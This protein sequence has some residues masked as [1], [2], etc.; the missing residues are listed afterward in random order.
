MYYDCREHFD[1]DTQWITVNGTHVP[2]DDNGKLSGDV[3]KKIIEESAKPKAR[4]KQSPGPSSRIAFKKSSLSSEKRE[5]YNRDFADLAT[6]MTDANSRCAAELKSIEK[7]QKGIPYNKRDFTKL[8]DEQKKRKEIS[9][10]FDKAVSEMPVGTLLSHEGVLYEKTKQGWLAKDARKDL[11]D[12]K[13]VED[14]EIARWVKCEDYLK[15]VSPVKCIESTDDLEMVRPIEM[16]SDDTYKSFADSINGVEKSEVVK[17]AKKDPEF[18]ELVDAITLYTQGAYGDQKREAKYLVEHGLNEALTT[19]AGDYFGDGYYDMKQ[20]WPGQKLAESKSSFSGGVLSMIGAINNSAETTERLYRIADDRAILSANGGK[21]YTPPKPGD[22]I[23]MDAPTSF[24]KSKEVMDEIS[25]T[26]YGDVIRYT[27]EPGAHALDIE[28]LSR[29]KQ[30]ESLCCGEF[31]VTKVSP[32][33]K[34]VLGSV[35][36]NAPPELLERVK[37]RIIGDHGDYY[38]TCAFKVE[39][40]LRQVGKTEIGKH[41]DAGIIYYDCRNHFDDDMEWITVNG[42]HIPLDDEGKPTGKIGEKIVSEAESKKNH[43]LSDEMAPARTDYDFSESD[44][45]NDFI[46]KNVP[47]LMPIFKK[48]GSEA[49]DSEFY[50]F[51]L[52]QSTKDIHEISKTEADEVVYDHVRQSLFDGWFRNA[53][54]SYK[55]A[56][57]SAMIGSQE[58]RNAG[59]SLAY[60]N[61]KN[62]AD[63]PL[64]FEEFL[65]TP[66]MMYRGGHG[67]KHTEDD[68]FSAYTFDKKT[69]EHFAGSNGVVTSAPIRPIDTYGSMRCV[70]EAEIWVP[71]E[72]APNGNQD[73]A[74]EVSGLDQ[75]L[76]ALGISK[77][78]F[79]DILKNADAKEELVAGLM[80]CLGNVPEL[81]EQASALLQFI[82]EDDFRADS[83]YDEWL[84]ENLDKFE[85][86]DDEIAFKKF[87]DQIGKSDDEDAETIDLVF[88]TW[89]QERD[90]NARNDS[91]DKDVQWITVNGTPVPL[92]ENGNITGKVAEKINAT[93]KRGSTAGRRFGKKSVR[94]AKGKL[95]KIDRSVVEEAMLSDNPIKYASENCYAAQENR[96]NQYIR[97]VMDNPAMKIAKDKY[98]RADIHSAYCKGEYIRNPE[99][100]LFTLYADEESYQT[101]MTR[102]ADTH[103]IND[104]SELTR[105]LNGLSINYPNLVGFTTTLGLETIDL[106]AMREDGGPGSGN[107]GHAGREG[108]IGG[109]APSGVTSVDDKYFPT[110]SYRRIT[111]QGWNKERRQYLS[112]KGFDATKVERLETIVTRHVQGNKVD[113]EMARF[114]KENP[115]LIMAVA[116]YEIAAAKK[117]REDE[118]A[119]A[120]KDIA[121]LNR[122]LEDTENGIKAG[123]Y[124]WYS[125]DPKEL[126]RLTEG[127]KDKIEY[128]KHRRAKLEDDS[129]TLYRA[130]GYEDNVLSFT[131]NPDGVVLY[132]G[133][134]YEQMLAP[135]HKNTLAE[136]V[137]E[138]IY[139]IGGFGAKFNFYAGE[140]SEVTFVKLRSSR[141][142]GGPGS[143]NFGHKGVPGQVGGSA[144]ADDE[145]SGKSTQRTPED[146]LPNESYQ[147]TPEFKE[148]VQAVRDAH[149]KRDEIFDRLKEMED[150]L[151]RE[152]SPKP[153][154]EWTEED[155]VDALL[156]NPPAHYTER[157]AALKKEYDE[158]KPELYKAA[159]EADAV[160]AEAG[161][162]MEI[163]RLKARSKQLAEWEQPELKKATKDQ[164]EGF[165]LETTGTSF[166]DE[167][168]GKRNTFIAEMSPKEYLERCAYEIFD[169]GTM[170]STV[171]GIIGKNAGKYAEEMKD[172]AKF[173][174]PY[175]NYNDGGQEGRHRA[176]AAYELGIDKIPVLIIGK[177]PRKSDLDF[178]KQMLGYEIRRKEFEYKD[179]YKKNDPV[180]DFDLSLLDLDGVGE[181]RIDGS[182]ESGNYGHKGIPGQ[183]GGSLPQG[184][185][186]KDSAER[187]AQK[188]YCANF[189]MKSQTVGT[190]ISK[191]ESIVEDLMWDTDWGDMDE[192]EYRDFL[193]K[194][195][196]QSEGY[197]EKIE[198]SEDGER[199]MNLIDVMKNGDDFAKF[200]AVSK[201]SGDRTALE[202]SKTGSYDAVIKA[203]MENRN[204]EAIERVES[205]YEKILEHADRYKKATSHISRTDNETYEKFGGSPT[206]AMDFYQICEKQHENMSL[207]D[208]QLER[209]YVGGGLGFTAEHLNYT[210]NSGG[211]ESLTEAE[212][213]LVDMVARNATAIDHDTILYRGTRAD[214]LARRLGYT[215]KP[216]DVGDHDF[217][218]LEITFDGIVSTASGGVSHDW[219]FSSVV[220]RYHVK[221]GTKVF[222]PDNECEGE[223]LFPAGLTCRVFGVKYSTEDFPVWASTDRKA[224]T[225][226]T[227]PFSQTSFAQAKG[228][229]FIDLEVG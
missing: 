204:R 215:G 196:P 20:L 153:K 71:R 192:D 70:G 82:V 11:K 168:L 106:K 38:S 60:E 197:I 14:S 7:D 28:K 222:V 89:R 34:I 17:R 149:A 205:L 46:N 206:P 35:P 64:S 5:S 78:T 202:C 165:T 19:T 146:F 173:H 190:R 37:D 169:R 210:M 81:Q 6:R 85:D 159:R 22:R 62:N 182:K 148:K 66:I 61:Y 137:S 52:A 68:V 54:S 144:P 120:D 107:F 32:V 16:K 74:D 123:E 143:G 128:A 94:D 139:P 40:T 27:L 42:A 117:R 77:N 227:M 25:P 111:A 194:N 91:D 161:D 191:K 113:D 207:D 124:S 217:S 108:E 1:D 83:A 157:G 36:K 167:Q 166:G 101:N 201:L 212:K 186:E 181:E 47:K 163:E 29:Y 116:S 150:E 220:V 193:E 43:K 110:D 63:K 221:A 228:R 24:T 45:V 209:A 98:E 162:W 18:K 174:L 13:A 155:E 112:A 154:N 10:A 211:T 86:D 58:M 216:E 132:A 59:L 156:G 30:K 26:K 218:G 15:P 56:L 200:L 125:S 199:H 145:S 105:M 99:T 131:T 55:P 49:V 151:K 51:R 2:L 160:I 142:D 88:K 104:K 133:T 171:N 224:G 126:E 180:D 41:E 214:T 195:V 90:L 23:K 100:L 225:Y 226:S 79:S 203:A 189:E 219:R 177:P 31:E 122:D 73:S 135:D 213:A 134:D 57:V 69:A 183:V 65:T 76:F 136:L 109:S 185:T 84:E 95:K 178:R 4:K 44:D 188:E 184:R 179:N 75:A 87:L 114:A 208:F 102:F 80:H 33:K 50:K 48:G 164:Y 121:D 175:L 170:E 8:W 127:I 129:V 187:R 140:G 229:V 96:V 97:S 72:I 118:I 12:G 158:V 93:S 147:D 130:G 115:D 172:G 3:G 103:G 67:Q 141:E 138:G 152:S 53:D 176:A 39:V 92:D 198:P 9:K 223:V 119:K 21:L